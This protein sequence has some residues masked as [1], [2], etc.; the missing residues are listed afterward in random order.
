MGTYFIYLSSLGFDV[1]GSLTEPQDSKPK[2]A[3][4]AHSPVLSSSKY[5]LSNVC[6]YLGLQFVTVVV[7]VSAP[8]FDK[9]CF[10]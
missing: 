6:M 7:I 4:F 1:K 5:W 3:I 10:R 9:P 2:S 8:S